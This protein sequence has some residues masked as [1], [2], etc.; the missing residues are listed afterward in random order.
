[1]KK[2]INRLSPHQNGKVFGVVM[3]LSSLVFVVPMTLIFAMMPNPAN[4]QGHQGAPPIIIFL[5]FPVIYLITGYIMTAIGCVI[6]NF[7]YKYIGGIEYD[8]LG[9]DA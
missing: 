5:I 4:Q 6:Y 1:M 7:T 2:Q 9:E 8:V 3:A